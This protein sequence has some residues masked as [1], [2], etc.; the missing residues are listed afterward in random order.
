[1]QTIGR[2]APSPSGRMHLGNVLCALLAWLSA[3][4]QNGR[5]LLRIEDL[6]AMRC[7]RSYADLILD[8]LR[9]LGLDWDGEVW[10]QS[11]R[12]AVYAQYEA[13]LR[14]QGLLYP[15]F[16]SRAALHAASAPHLSDG[17][18]VY[19]GTCRDLTPAQ[20]AEKRRSRAPATRV[21]VPA[22]QIGFVDAVRGAYTEDLAQT[23]GDF[24]IRRSDGVYAYQLAVVVDDALSGVT[25][26]VRGDDLIASTPR[27]IW[28]HRLFGFAPP[29]FAHIPLLCDH[30]GR[31]LSKRDEDLDLG[32]LRARFT[33][34]Q[35]IG[36]LACAAGLI[37]RPEPVAAHELIAGFS[38]DALP[39]HD[40]HL[41]AVFRT[42]LDG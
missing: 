1:M 6:D 8:D 18:V 12:A 26:V 39:R 38:W 21:R 9:W 30:D 7:P 24:I 29:A 19:A 15:C 37:D 3:R 25:E 36:A 16:C 10:Y 40:L 34:A 5:Y 33:P 14:G 23:C 17:R 20:V 27:Q 31:R 32:L 2:F 35:V 28:L 13:I 42:P 11:E 22:A 41:P 4:R